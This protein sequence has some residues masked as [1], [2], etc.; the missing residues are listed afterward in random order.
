MQ[1]SRL[2]ALALLSFALPLAA[3]NSAA[4]P[5]PQI[6]TGSVAPEFTAPGATKDGV[7]KSVSLSQYKGKTVVLA[8]FY[9]ARTKG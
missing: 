3:Q 2:L 7:I 8:F 1:R 9:Q 5:A 6:D 4:A